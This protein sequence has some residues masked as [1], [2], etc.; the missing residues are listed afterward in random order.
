MSFCKTTYE[1]N[2]KKKTLFSGPE[3]M[4]F[5]LLDNNFTNWAKVTRQ[6]IK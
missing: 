6:H 4:P 1:V 5:Q 2:V 3:S